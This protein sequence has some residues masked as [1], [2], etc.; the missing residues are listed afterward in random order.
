MLYKLCHMAL[1]L[2]HLCY[3]SPLPT[4][5]SSGCLCHGGTA[6]WA[7]CIKH[8]GWAF[9]ASLLPLVERSARSAAAV[10]PLAAPPFSRVR[11]SWRNQQQ[12][13]AEGEAHKFSEK[14]SSVH[15]CHGNRLC[16]W[17]LCFAGGKSAAR[18]VSC[19]SCC[20]C[21]CWCSG[22]RYELALALR[23]MQP[24]A[25]CHVPRATALPLIANMCPITP[26]KF[27]LLCTIIL[28][29]RK[30]RLRTKRKKFQT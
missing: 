1:L 8:F 17:P 9:F 10:A 3:T 29:K 7:H 20:C 11:F 25:A 12:R 16:L 21:C 26:M 19:R 28:E 18:V 6:F 27:E 2:P 24:L 4:P 30:L 13:K 5:P 15:K 22:S 23:L 14:F